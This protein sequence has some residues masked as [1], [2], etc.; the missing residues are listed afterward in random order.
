V[1]QDGPTDVSG[2][3]THGDGLIHIHPFTRSAAGERATMAKFFDQVD[4]KVT[5]DGF[6]LPDGLTVEGG[7]STVKTGE[8][9]CGGDE[10][11]LVLA[12]WEDAR[13]AGSTEPDDII[14]GGFESVRFE[15][16]LSAYTLAFVPTGSTDIAAPSAS[17]EIESLGAADAGGLP[18]GADPGPANVPQVEVPAEGEAPVEDTTETSPSEAE[19]GGGQ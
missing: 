19:T 9:T 2:I 14:R 7:G 6:Q 15:Q 10:G 5:D 1:L 8:T 4:L 16:D 17:A 12:F 18:P 11:E 13:A 3:H